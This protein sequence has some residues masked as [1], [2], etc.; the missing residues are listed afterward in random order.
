MHSRFVRPETCILK[1]SRGE[2][3][4]VKRRLNAG[5]QRA[6]FVRLYVAGADGELKTNPFNVGLATIGAYLVD[7]SL[8]DDD[9]H[10]VKIQ[11][12]SYEQLTLIL[13]GLDTDSFKEIREAIEA[14]ENAMTEAR[15]QEKKLPAGANGSSATTTLPD[16]AI[17]V[18]SGSMNSIQMSTT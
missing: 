2:T 12:L 6:R 5:E 10:L 17:G 8:T 16:E 18:T 14:H 7:W 3:L 15:T 9:G 4:T 11:G 13:D 1:I